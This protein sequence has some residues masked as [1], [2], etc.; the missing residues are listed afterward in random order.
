MSAAKKSTDISPMFE[1]ARI[2]APCHGGDS[3][4]I[5]I[6][7]GLQR[8]QNRHVRENGKLYWE[9]GKSFPQLREEGLF[10]L[11]R[12]FELQPRCLRTFF[13]QLECEMPIVPPGF[14]R[15]AEPSFRGKMLFR[16][17]FA[18][19]IEFEAQMPPPITFRLVRLQITGNVQV[20]FQSVEGLIEQ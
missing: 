9:V 2:Q 15:E 20:I 14:R 11:Q 7:E 17:R 12:W 1:R 3:E 13:R 5:P 19:R 8:K 6:T 10:R 4:Y 16:L 18:L